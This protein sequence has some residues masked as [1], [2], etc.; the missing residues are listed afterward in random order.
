MENNLPEP[1][2]GNLT[3]LNEGEK[4][5][6][7]LHLQGK[8][9]HSLDVLRG[10]AVLGALLA[11]IWI[12][13]GFSRNMQTNLL[14][15]PSGGNYRL[16]ATISL[17]FVGKMR[18]L[19]AVVFGA[20]MVLFLSKPNTLNN[21]SVPDLFIRRQLWLIALGLINGLLFLWTDDLLFHLGITGILLFA[22]VRLSP[23]TLFIAATLLTLVYCGKVYWRYSDDKKM[24]QKYLA[25]T[26]LEKTFKKDSANQAKKDKSPAQQK[27]VA[28][29]TK[30]KADSVAQKKDTLTKQQQEDKSAWEGLVKGLKYDPKNDEEEIKKMRSGSY[31]EL[32]S[33]LLP[34]LQF[35]EAAWTYRIGIWDLASMMLLGM[36]LAKIGFFTNIFSRKKYFLIAIA[37]ITASLLLGWFRLYFQNA[38]LLNY[39]KYI[40]HYAVPFDIFFPIERVLLAIGYTALVMSLLQLKIL[41]GILSAL[42][43]TGKMALTNYLIQ[44]IFL[45]LFFT[46]FG[47]TYFGKLQQYQLYVLVAEVWLVQVVFS[48][49]WLRNFSYGPA[50]WLLRSLTYGKKL[51]ISSYKEGNTKIITTAV[52]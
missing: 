3:P 29:A 6:G 30:S 18:A 42:A 23:R 26:T 28:I 35:K 15:H 12:F 40:N 39:E 21:V 46:G 7:N 34:T 50:E 1:V 52:I 44:S 41:Q 14:L 36:G 4:V 16:F 25:V 45:S 10:I 37:G 48:V 22:F 47:M 8:R 2:D 17:L 51:T 24:Y 38:T 9:I 11:S 13:G 43:D 31:G 32:W 27:T 20:G 5:A 19:I 49:I 33:H